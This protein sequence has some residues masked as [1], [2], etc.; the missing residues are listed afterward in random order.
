MLSG[1]TFARSPASGGSR[2]VCARW[3]RR[4]V[5]TTCPKG[6]QRSRDAPREERTARLGN[7][8]NPLQQYRGV[9]GKGEAVESD[10]RKGGRTEVLDD[11]V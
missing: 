9:L 11:F 1:L 8:G 7:T 3:W 10:C 4:V 6:P 2:R 5:E